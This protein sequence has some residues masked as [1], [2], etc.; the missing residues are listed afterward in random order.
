[1]ERSACPCP[2]PFTI[3]LGAAG[4]FRP[5][6]SHHPSASSK[7]SPSRVCATDRRRHGSLREPTSV[8]YVRMP[9]RP[10]SAPAAPPPPGA[11]RTWGGK[12]AGAAVAA[13]A[14][15]DPPATLTSWTTKRKFDQYGRMVEVRRF[16][17]VRDEYRD[18]LTSLISGFLLP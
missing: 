11:G 17:V 18:L 13:T 15:A 12:G 2:A 8:R 14:A 9:R 1:M 6:P 3:I 4:A 7:W 5:D 10:R 16:E